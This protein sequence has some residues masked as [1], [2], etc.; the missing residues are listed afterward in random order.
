[1]SP[2]PIPS[3][4]PNW[5]FLAD[6]GELLDSSL[7][8]QSTLSNVLQLA[9]P[10]IADFA[11]IALRAADGSMSW[12]SSVHRDPGKA[13][14][15]ARLMEFQPAFKN[16]THP[17]AEYLRSGTPVVF[18]L[19]DDQFL[20]S[21]AHNQIHFA[22]L[23][24][25]SFTSL[26]FVPL[27]AR[28]HDLGILVFGVAADSGRRYGD[29]D[30]TLAQELGR[31]AALAVDNALLYQKAEEAA[32]ARE[33][34]MGVVS[35]DLK[36]P[37]STISMAASFLLEEVIPDDG[38]HTVERKQLGAV[39]RA[40]ERMFR[41]IHDLLDVTAVEAGRIS[42]GRR[43]VQ[44]AQPLI[45]EAADVLRPLA[46]AKQIRFITDVAAG[47]P[48]VDVDRDRLLQVFSNLGGNAIKF[49]PENGVVRVAATLAGDSVEFTVSDTGPGI[50]D[51]D[52]A[53]VFD[54]FWQA[55]NTA[56]LGTG[57]G[58]AIAKGIVEAHGGQI[59]VS[60]ELGVGTEF[61]F[62]IPVGGAQAG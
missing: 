16:P 58:L 50:A 15:A 22:I 53:Q 54:R 5:K 19:I 31:R 18:D 24:A 34:M 51:P 11:A 25:L 55:K 13:A 2:Q 7:D 44:A 46:E 17:A 61:V 39:Q 8:Y 37:L 59:R 60:S 30:L 35:H 62:T 10:A 43:R 20:E 23:K 41:L 49:T 9:V 33:V 29:T 52:L 14:A 57:L 21:I 42:L 3:G 56:H 40:A 47:L 4:D 48:M 28:D 1:L 27:R 26:I 32:R 6:A 38:A 45:D 36:N 12:G